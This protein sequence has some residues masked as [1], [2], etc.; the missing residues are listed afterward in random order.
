MSAG[1]IRK[2]RNWVVATRLLRREGSGIERHALGSIRLQLLGCRN[3]PRE[4]AGEPKT[5][6]VLDDL[7]A[8]AYLSWDTD[9]EARQRLSHHRR[10]RYIAAMAADKLPL[11]TFPS[12]SAFE[13]RLDVE[14]Q[15]V[16]LG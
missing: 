4:D 6:A 5:P 2:S 8:S 1:L 15:E 14:P 11:L 10:V 12:A 9:A 16:V 13:A 3:G 7:T